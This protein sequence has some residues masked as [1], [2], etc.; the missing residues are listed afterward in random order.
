M[1]L[2]QQP[3]FILGP[4]LGWLPGTRRIGQALATPLGKTPSPLTDAPPA[5]TQPFPESIVAQA[6]RG[7]KYDLG[8]LGQGS[9]GLMSSAPAF[10]LLSRTDGQGNVHGFSAHAGELTISSLIN[11][12]KY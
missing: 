4:V 1:Q 8:A 12:S 5:A 11:S 3:S 6:L 10:Q 9:S 2:R 7:Q